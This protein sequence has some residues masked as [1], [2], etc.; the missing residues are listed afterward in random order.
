MH[1]PVFHLKLNST[2]YVCPYLTGNTLRLR[3]ESNRLMLS[4]GLWRWHI[5]VTITIPD[6]VHRPVFYSKLNSTLYVCPYLTGNT[7][8]LRY[9]SNRLMLSIGLWRWY[10]NITTTIPDIV[11]RP[12]FY[13][14]LN[15]T[16]YVCP[17]LTG[18]LLRLRYEPSK[19]MLTIGL[20]R[21]YIDILHHP[22]SYLELSS[23]DRSYVAACS[24]KVYLLT[25][26]FCPYAGNR[27]I[28]P[29]LINIL[30][31]LSTME[32]YDFHETQAQC[33]EC[34]QYK[35]CVTHP[36]I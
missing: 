2:L 17:Y 29:E 8:R 19:L 20:W 34:I 13:I 30:W 35:H 25:A 22:V 5:N 31:D 16:L 15:S 27:T 11:H 36:S 1:R 6:I 21:W 18:N 32:T 12:V 4:I 23:Q 9:E 3:Y 10:I 24:L 26:H 14:K 7:L 28:V 33:L